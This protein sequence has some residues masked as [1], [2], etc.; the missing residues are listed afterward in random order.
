LDSDTDN[1]KIVFEKLMETHPE[2][3]IGTVSWF[4]KKYDLGSNSLYQY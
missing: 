4:K 2:V 1:A 3:E